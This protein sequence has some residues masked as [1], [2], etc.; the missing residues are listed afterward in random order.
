MS[1]VPQLSASAKYLIG[2]G[3]LVASVVAWLFSLRATDAMPVGIPAFVALWTVMMTAM[4]LPSVM[5]AVLLFATVAQS[6]TQYGFSVAPTAVFVVGYLGVW[7]LTGVAIACVN[8]A[9][10][11]AITMSNWG[12]MFIGGALVAGGVYQFTRWKMICLGYCR[13]PI[14]FFMEHWRDGLVG[15]IQMGAHHGLYCL[16]CCWG[17]TLALIALGLMNPVWMIAS[18]LLIFAEKVAPWGKRFARVIGA[19]LILAGIGVAFG[20]IPLGHATGGM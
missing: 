8:Q 3:L 2:G 14:Q 6:R 13:E 9:S 17:L 4:M 1:N 12:R 11:G 5:P 20:W 16:G 19:A 10:G 7:A 15:A 18:A